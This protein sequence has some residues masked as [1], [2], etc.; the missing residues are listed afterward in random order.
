MRK[1]LRKKLYKKWLV[2]CGNW[3]IFHKDTLELNKKLLNDFEIQMK[4]F[5]WISPYINPD[6][7]SFDFKYKP[8]EFWFNVVK[9][10]PYNITN[11]VWT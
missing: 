9:T 11:W 2:D 1:R 3:W 6:W 5:S 7:K 4:E 10:N 8:F